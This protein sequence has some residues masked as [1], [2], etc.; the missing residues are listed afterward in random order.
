[1]IIL[2]TDIISAFTK[3]D[4]LN[5]IL[6]LFDNKVYITPE[7]Y[8]ELQA[9]LHYGYSY[10]KEIFKKIK[11]LTPTKKEQGIY[12]ATLLENMTLGRGELEA[13][14]VAKERNY[15]FS[16]LD[17]KAIEFAKNKGVRIVVLKAILKEFLVK[18]ACS[19]EELKNLIKKIEK[20][21]NRKIDTEGVFG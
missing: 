16:S 13:I 19:E 2:D 8:K 11:I 6:K 9:P 7:I 14:C 10:P 18:K 5:M 17:K 12:L 21:D 1:M 20:R 4:S 3:A 15:G